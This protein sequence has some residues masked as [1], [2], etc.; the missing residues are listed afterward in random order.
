MCLAS[1]IEFSSRR[2]V[3][4][5]MA[6]HRRAELVCEALEMAISSR[7]P[8]VGLISTRIGEPGQYTSRQFGDL[9]RA[10]A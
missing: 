2:V 1:V 5:V 10:T 3:G 7:R 8:R 9:L 4:W 6:D